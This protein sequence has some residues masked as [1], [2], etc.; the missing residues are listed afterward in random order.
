MTDNLPT[1]AAL[2]SAWSDAL[3]RLWLRAQKERA[4]DERHR[5]ERA[6]AVEETEKEEP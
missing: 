1:D 3:L 6:E 2:H 5:Q 4:C